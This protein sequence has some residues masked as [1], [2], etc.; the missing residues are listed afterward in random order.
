MNSCKDCYIEYKGCDEACLGCE[1]NPQHK[2][3]KPKE[4]LE[5]NFRMFRKYEFAWYPNKREYMERSQ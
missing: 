2:N 5:E 4:N 1:D 3:F